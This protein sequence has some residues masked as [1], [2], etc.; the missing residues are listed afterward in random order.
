MKFQ[1]EQVEG[2]SR[3]PGGLRQALPER[4]KRLLNSLYW[5]ACDARDGVLV[6]EGAVVAAGAV[7][8]RDVEPYQIVGGVPARPI[9]ERGRELTYVLDYRKFLG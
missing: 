8:T 9:G 6:G 4:L 7:V 1:N 5:L 2:K 3:L